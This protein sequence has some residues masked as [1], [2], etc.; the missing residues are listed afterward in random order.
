MLFTLSSLLSHP[1]EW[2]ASFTTCSLYKNRNKHKN[3]LG[4]TDLPHDDG[5]STGIHP[6][7]GV[8]VVFYEET[9]VQAKCGVKLIALE[10]IF[11]DLHDSFF[12]K[13]AWRQN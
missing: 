11:I 5:L 6:A 4:R 12:Y 13:S 9:K 3:R 8:S 10:K 1:L 2:F 7:L